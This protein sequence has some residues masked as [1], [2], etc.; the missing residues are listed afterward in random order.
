MAEPEFTQI[1]K[2]EAKYIRDGN[3]ICRPLPP[4]SPSPTG[5]HHW[6]EVPEVEPGIFV[7]K[8]CLENRNFPTTFSESVDIR[9]PFATLGGVKWPKNETY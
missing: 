5:A 1:N 6:I 2:R 4:L 9:N 7:C 8:Y 3:W